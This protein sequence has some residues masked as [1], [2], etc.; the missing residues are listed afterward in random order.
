MSYKRLRLRIAVMRCK[1]CNF[2]CYKLLH[3]S[4]TFNLCHQ[5]RGVFY[6]HTNFVYH[7]RVKPFEISMGNCSNMPHHKYVNTIT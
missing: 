3:V 5:D 2:P 6:F 1:Q 7:N 4:H